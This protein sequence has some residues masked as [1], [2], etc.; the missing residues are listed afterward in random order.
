MRK[1]LMM[2][3]FG[4]T[5]CCLMD[6]GYYFPLKFLYQKDTLFTNQYHYSLLN[7]EKIRISI[8]NLKAK[9]GRPLKKIVGKLVQTEWLAY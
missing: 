6:V 8:K 9:R 2:M 7:I 4:H 1:E 5:L 3:V